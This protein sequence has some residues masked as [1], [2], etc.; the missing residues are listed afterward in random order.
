MAF[1]A[2]MK[3]T[4]EGRVAKYQDGFTTMAK[5]TAHVKKHKGKFA[6]REPATPWNHWRIDV[7]GKTITNERPEAREPDPE[8][9]T[10]L[11]I[12]D[13]ADALGA[14]SVAKLENRIGA[15]RP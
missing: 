1:L 14:E 6:V 12:R 11:A 3:I 10:I 4:P 9:D 15:R 8:S 5:A 2:I 13:L 7:G